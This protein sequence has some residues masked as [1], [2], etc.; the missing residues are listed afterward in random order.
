MAYRLCTYWGHRA[1]SSKHLASL[2][3]YNLTQPLF[4]SLSVAFH[5]I[6]HGGKVT[7][8]PNSRKLKQRK[9]LSWEHCSIYPSAFWQC[10]TTF[11]NLVNN[12]RTFLRNQKC[13]NRLHSNS[14]NTH[15]LTIYWKIPWLFDGILIRICF[16]CSID[17]LILWR[18]LTDQSHNINM[19]Y[20]N[21]TF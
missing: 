15:T 13:R 10:E 6:F 16:L 3:A 11:I 7:V 12:Y 5:P 2:I 14:T 1:I 9:V 4:V 17:L 21:Y 19:L 18:I 20:F 8:S